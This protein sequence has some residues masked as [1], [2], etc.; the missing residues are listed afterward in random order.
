LRTFIDT[1]VWFAAANIR[2]RHNAR[3]KTIL[4]EIS[5]A[6]LTDY[7]LIETWRLL[8]S[9]MHRQAAEGFWLAVRRGVAELER[10]T[11]VDL[12]AAWAIG[13]FFSGQEFS[14]VD[15]VSFAVM[16]RLGLMHVA[17][18]DNDFAVYR[19]GRARERAFSV[20]R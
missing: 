16:E 8:N 5:T 7:V 13:Q 11:P 2:D 4:S 10:V 17:S 14:I 19:F 18:F 20:I 6:V 15:R 3:A 12:E 9:R 1:S